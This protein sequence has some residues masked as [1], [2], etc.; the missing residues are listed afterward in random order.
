MRRQVCVCVSGWL[1]FR[2]ITDTTVKVIVMNR[3]RVAMQL[4]Y[5]NGRYLQ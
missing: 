5:F 3:T 1:L 2:L 4:R